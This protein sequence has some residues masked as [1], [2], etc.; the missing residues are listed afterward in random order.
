MPIVRGERGSSLTRRSHGGASRANVASGELLEERSLLSADYGPL[1]VSALLASTIDTN[2]SD[3]SPAVSG[4]LAT[5]LSSEEL[6]TPQAGTAIPGGMSP[7]AIRHAYGFDQ[8]FFDGGTI[9]GDGTG[10]TIAIVNA[11]HTPT[12]AN[13]LAAFNAY[14]GLP[15]PPSFT[16]VDQWGGTDYPASNPDWA[17]ETLL[18]I[19]WAHAF[20]PGADILLVEA[21]TA[22]FPDLMAAVDY[23]RNY[24]GVSVVSLSWGA[25]EWAGETSYNTY[26]TTPAGHEGVTFFAAAGNSGGPGMYPAYSPNVMAV[27]GTTLTLNGSNNIQSETA[28]SGSGGGISQ[29]QTK[30]SWQ[31]G[32]VTQSATKRTMPDVAFNGNPITGVAV[33]DTFNNSPATPWRKIAGTSFAT[34]S[35]AALVAVANQGRELA[36]LSVFNQ[37]TLMTSIY[38]MPATNFNDITSGSSGGSIPQSAGVGY[39]LVSGRGSPKVPLVVESLI[40]SS[41]TPSGISLVAASDTGVS[42]SDRITKL[43][44]ATAG[45]KLSFQVT[46]TIAGATVSVYDGDTLIGSAVASGT[47]TTVVT[48]GSLA[49]SDGSHSITARQTQPGKPQSSHSPAVSV[50]IDTAAPVATIGTVSPDPRPAGV[51]SMSIGFSEVVS[52]VTLGNL[53][54]R[55]DGGA[56]LLGGGQSLS[57]IDNVNWTLGNLLPPT[58][59]AGFY[60]LLFAGTPGVIDVAGNAAIGDAEEFTVAASVLGRR[61]F[62]N[63]SKFDGANAAINADD[64]AA[65][66]P[67]KSAYLAGS[68]PATFDNISSYS[69]GINGV[70]IDLAGS[71]PDITAADFQFRMG[72]SDAL[73]SWTAAPAPLAVAVRSGAGAGGSDRVEIVW[74]NGAIANQWLEVTLLPTA[75][76][77]LAAPDIFYFGSRIGDTG[78]GTAM[79]AITNATDEIDTRLSQGL[80]SSITNVH[81][82]DRSGMVNATDS[83]TSRTNTGLLW[84]INLAAPAAAPQAAPLVAG[85]AP[86]VAAEEAPSAP[87]IVAPAVEP[88]LASVHRT[89]DTGLA[90]AIALDDSRKPDATGETQEW[91]GGI[92]D[93]LVDLL[94]SRRR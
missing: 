91:Q 1:T 11:Y 82:F 20:A 83:I 79:V 59:P 74:A 22:S 13:D 68:G 66:A 8:V 10:Q 24:P 30:P 64:D 38:G 69:R 28:W 85:F 47:T 31:N 60:E 50:T 4:P 36:G 35:W 49:L 67:D 12:A 43:N 70:M 44:N 81:D 21:E 27:G 48:N 37:A 72:N 57:T 2:L 34:P 39:D 33:Y 93:A 92:A 19:Q 3:A 55:R 17:L 9:V 29:Y 42:S 53:T 54:L 46:G 5:P 56:N 87:P 23:A 75:N 26:L 61:L 16:Q 71:H 86:Q 40:G 78:S 45:T 76:T 73:G 89:Q 7:Q 15:A 63:E 65:I 6:A 94:A 41:V 18:D 25:G 51:G 88:L 77:S 90:F 62:Y 58:S 32:V 14:F 80:G 52:G 84:K